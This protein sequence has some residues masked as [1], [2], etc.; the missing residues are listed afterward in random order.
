MHRLLGTFRK[1]FVAGVINPDRK[2]QVFCIRERVDRPQVVAT[3]RHVTCG[4]P[5]LESVS[6]SGNTLSRTSDIVG[7]DEYAIYLTE[8]AGLRF[9][10]VRA[11]GAELVSDATEGAMHAVRL[12]SAVS[13]RVSWTVRYA[14][15]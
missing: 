5:D 6:W 1:G 13:A 4:G 15:R 8:P 12:R 14:R 10:D 11:Q 2:V 3:N 9:R 7:G